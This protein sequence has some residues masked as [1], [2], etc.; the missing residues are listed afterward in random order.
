MSYILIYGST[1]G[2]SKFTIKEV[3]FYSPNLP[4]TFEGFRIVQISDLHLKYWNDTIPIVKMVNMVNDLN[5]DLIAVTGDLVHIEASETTDF[6][7]T[8]SRLNAPYG[9]F[10]IMGNHDYG[11]YRR[12]NSIMEQAENLLDLQNSI[13][14]MGW[15]SLDND[16]V[17]LSNGKELIALIGVENDG[18]GRFKGSGDLPKAM[19]GTENIKFKIL[20]SHNPTHWKREVLDTDIDLTLSGHTHAM[21]FAIGKFSFSSYKYKEWGGLYLE[22]NQ[23]LYVNV[24]I[25]T[26]GIPFRFGAYPEITLITLSKTK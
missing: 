4:E 16:H 11:N 12:W 17:F 2:K 3:T 21:Q 15:I 22:G 19:Q 25:G 26:V 18:E 14:N 7:E 23:A 10:F 24:G 8:L 20:L 6:E 1:L 9:V 5:P 13:K